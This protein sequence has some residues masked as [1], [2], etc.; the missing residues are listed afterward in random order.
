MLVGYGVGG[1]SRGSLLQWMKRYSSNGS[2]V[3]RRDGKYFEPLFLV[4]LTVSQGFH[5]GLLLFNLFINDLSTVIKTIF[6]LFAGDI[7]VFVRVDSKRSEEKSSKCHGQ[8]CEMLQ[9]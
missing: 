5:L 8:C 9:C 2:L 4:L 3:V 6:L 1:G 7:K